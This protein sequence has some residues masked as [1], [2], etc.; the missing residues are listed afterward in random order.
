ME[1]RLTLSS[2]LKHPAVSTLREH[3]P[4]VLLGLFDV[5]VVWLVFQVRSWA[6]FRGDLGQEGFDDVPE[7]WWDWGSAADLLLFG[8]DAG[9]WAANARA[10]ME[11]T[12]PDLH[13][14]PVYGWLT[15]AMTTVFPDYAFAGHLVNHLASAMV[16]VVTY[17]LGRATSGRGAGL[18]AALLV[19]M[20]P[21]LINAQNLYG[22]DP[23]MNLLVVLLVLVGWWAMTGPWWVV[24]ITGVIAGLCAGTHYLSM[25]F[26][27]PVA[28]LMLLHRGDWRRRVLAPIAVLCIAWLTFQALL[29]PYPPLSLSQAFSVYSEG[30]VGSHDRADLSGGGMWAA[31]ELVLS[32][33]DG[34]PHTAVQ[35]GLSP[36]LAG[37]GWWPLLGA[38]WIGLLGP[39]LGRDKTMK[40]GWDWRFGVWLLV[41]MAPLV[42]LEGARAPERYRYYAAPLVMLTVARGVASVCAAVDLGG[43]R[44]HRLWPSGLL[45]VLVCGVLAAQLFEPLRA[46]WPGVPPLDEGVHERAVGLAVKTHFGEGGGV[47]TVNQAIPF[48]AGREKCP[49]AMCPADGEAKVRACRQLV[50]QQCAGTGDIPWIVDIRDNEGFADR[51]DVEIDAWVQE[52]FSYVDAVV[53]QGRKTSI[54]R[55]PRKAL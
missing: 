21:Q 23:V 24:P 34:T 54:Y 5:L 28:L 18:G 26:P 48:Y 36:L 55:V 25:L 17:F 15:G 37:V 3:G 10:L 51:R 41:L 39:L 22:V 52:N 29:I 16:C 32:K 14:L 38:F 1:A 20:S 50:R 40:W 19:A 35:T 7:S 27:L 53:T 46:A 30:V 8:P 44:L 6:W 45:A 33:L 11:G 43:R 49:Q 31:V 2:L 13:R 12:A 4:K 9:N 47:V 42:L